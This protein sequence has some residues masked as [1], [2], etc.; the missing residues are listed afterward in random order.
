[1]DDQDI[2]RAARLITKRHGIYAEFAAARRVDEMIEAG[3]PR[4]ET[5]WKRILRAVRELQRFKP[6]EGEAMN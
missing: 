1:M 5:T 3:D 4:G 6:R 2:W